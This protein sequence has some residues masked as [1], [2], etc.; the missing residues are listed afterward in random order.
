MMGSVT[1]FCEN[2]FRKITDKNFVTAK[3]D[4]NMF[5]SFLVITRI[6]L[7]VSSSCEH[8][9]NLTEEMHIPL[10]LIPKEDCLSCEH[11][12]NL[13]EEMHIPLRLMPK[14]DCLSCEH[15]SNLTEEMHIPLRLIPKEDCLSLMFL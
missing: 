3:S 6:L 7:Y 4:A 12:S 15:Q 14:E 8:Q 9:S 11:Q 2:C 1:L 5:N 10:R 13:T